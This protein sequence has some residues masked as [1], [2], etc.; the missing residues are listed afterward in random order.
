MSERTSADA[1]GGVTVLGLGAMGTALARTL[2][3]AGHPVTVWNRTRARAEALAAEGATVADTPEAATA[4]NPLVI[5]CVLDYAAVRQT[6]EPAAAALAGRALVNLTN[7]TPAQAGETAAWANGHGADYLD[8]GIM[9]IPPMIG[10]PGATLLYSGSRAAFDTHQRTLERFGVAAYLDKDPGAAPLYDIALLSAMYGLFGGALHAIA[11]VG[12]GEGRATEFTSTL[13]LPWL[14]AM[15]ASV[16]EF[17]RQLDT[18][19]FDSRAATSN[20][21]MQAAAYANL[22]DASETA[23]VDPLLLRPMGELLRR[24]AAE[25]H[26]DRD[27]PALGTLLRTERR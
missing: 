7:G 2:L 5:V 27:V 22:L 21:A 3:A 6:L 20:L 26:G 8:G 1:A 18:G 10:H 14:Q 16:P 4:A 24:A 23:G 13:L 12:P 9:A 19:D 11:L 25:G 17:A 15:M